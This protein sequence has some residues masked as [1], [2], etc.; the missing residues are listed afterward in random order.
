[1]NVE[2]SEAKYRNENDKTNDEW[3]KDDP[4][5]ALPF[6]GANNFCLG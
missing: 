5:G 3:K 4:H 2:P 6:A 1:M